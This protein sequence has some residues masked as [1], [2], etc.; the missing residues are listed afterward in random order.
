[1]LISFNLCCYRKFLKLIWA[2]RV[3]N[4]EST[5]ENNKEAQEKFMKQRSSWNR[6][7]EALCK[8]KKRRIQLLSYVEKNDN[9]LKTIIEG[10]IE[11]KRWERK[12]TLTI[13][14][15]TNR[16]RRVPWIS[17]NETKCRDA[18]WMEDCYQPIFKLT[19]VKEMRNMF[20]R[21]G[22]SKEYWYICT[23]MKVDCWYI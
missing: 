19:V 2:H 16:E 8:T 10:T 21:G 20:P 15:A 11:R 23:L 7:R 22:K 3:T 17:G 1:M 18:S 13:Y 4:V 12:A 9:L 5:G 6:R 14:K